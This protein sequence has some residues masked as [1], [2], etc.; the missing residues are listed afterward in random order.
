M[1]I[2][3][4]EMTNEDK[5]LLE[6]MTDEKDENVL[7]TYYKLAKQIVLLHAFP[8]GNESKTVPFRYKRVWLEI[9]A[10]MLN[11]RGAEGETAHIENGISR[12]YEAGSIPPSILRRIV[13]H[14]EV[15]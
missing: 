5:E 6:Y 1:T 7:S 10:Y 12:Y 13:P 11:K 3:K 2:H 14:A 4:E 15:L 9:A 8:F